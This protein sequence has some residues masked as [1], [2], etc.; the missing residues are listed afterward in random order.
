M[1]SRPFS[2]NTACLTLPNQ[3]PTVAT[4]PMSLPN[5]DHDAIL[6]SCYL[7]STTT[8]QRRKYA[9]PQIVSPAPSTDFPVS[10]ILIISYPAGRLGAL[11]KSFQPWLLVCKPLGKQIGRRKLTKTKPHA[12]LMSQCRGGQNAG[13]ER[14]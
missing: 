4:I 7:A 2:R 14:V 13:G 12:L 1:T 11:Y 10:G 9:T 6:S 8:V 5:D 3:F